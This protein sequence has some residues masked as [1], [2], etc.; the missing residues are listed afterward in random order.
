MDGQKYVPTFR[1]AHWCRGHAHIRH[2]QMILEQI[3]ELPEPTTRCMMSGCSCNEFDSPLK[4]PAV[5]AAL[6]H[7]AERPKSSVE[8]PLLLELLRKRKTMTKLVEGDEPAH[9]PSEPP[10]PP[11]PEPEKPPEEVLTLESFVCKSC[12]HSKH[13]HYNYYHIPASLQPAMA[14]HKRTNTWP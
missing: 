9:K 1:F 4:K 3:K 8:N 13:F 2:S 12:S 11:P 10:P 5:Q 7:V 6:K 14:E